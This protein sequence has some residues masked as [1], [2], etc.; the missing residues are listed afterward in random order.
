ME[1]IRFDELI[2]SNIPVLIDFYAEWCGPCMTFLPV[3]QELKN[4]FGEQIK[5]IKIDVDKHLDLVQK[6]QIM[7]VPTI[8]IYQLGELVWGAPGVPTKA[9]LADKLSPL[10]QAAT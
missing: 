1:K 9:F 2:Q 10:V 8:M 6:I 7:G 5:I 4:E 3:L